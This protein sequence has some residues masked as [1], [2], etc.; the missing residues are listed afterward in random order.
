MTTFNFKK[1]N[2]LLGWTV[3]AIALIVYTMTV[4]PTLSFWDC[5]EYIATAAKLEVGHPPGAPLFQMMGA[6]FAMFATS[7]SQVAFMVNMVSVVSSAFTILFLFWSVTILLKNILSR[8]GEFTNSSAVVVLGSAFVGALAFTFSDSFWFNATEAEVYAMASLFIALLLWL[9]LRWEQDMHTPRGNKWLLIISLIVGLSFGVHFMALLAIPAIGFLYFFKN[10]EKVTVK[11]FIIANV[12]IVAILLFIFKFLLPYTM[13]L[14]GKTEI[15]M[16]NSLGMPFNSGTIFM[17]LLIVAFFYFG[18][19]YTRKKQLPL[20][21]TILLCT[22]F[23]L[24][25]FSTWMMLPIRAN[26]N[27]VINENRPSDAAEVLAYYNREQ[28]GEQQ[29]FYGPMFSDIYAGLDKNNPY[30]DEKPNYQRDYKKGKYVIVN[31]YK[32]AK[33]NTDDNHKGFMPRM[34]STDHA[35]NYMRFTE[36]LDFRLDPNIDYDRELMQYGINPEQMTEDE[37][38]S[39]INQIRGE[40]EKTI[41]QFKTAYANGDI[42]LEGYDQF[43][44]SYGQYLIIEKPSFTQNMKYMFEYQFGYM[45]WRYFMWNFAGRQNDIQGRYDNLDGNWISGIGLIDNTHIGNQDKLSSDQKNNKGRNVYYMIPLLLGFIGLIYHAFKDVKSFYV[46]LVLFLFTGL[47]L[48]IYLNE[49]PFEPRE[50]DYALV[51]SFFVF[52]MWIGFGVYAIYEAIVKYITPKIAG[53]VVIAVTLLGAPVLMASQNWD[54]H[55][56]ADRYTALA[57]AKAYL[58]SCDENAILFTIGDNDTFPLWY[59]QEIEGFRTDVRIVNTSLLMTDWYIDQMKRQAYESAPMPISFEHKQYVQGTRDYMLHI[60]ERDDRWDI[61]TFLQFLGSD[62]PRVKKELNNGHKVNY[63]STNKIRLDV[64]RK[65]VIENKIVAPAQYDS[66]VPY[67]DINIKGDAL[68]KNRMIMLDILANNNWERPIY[69]TGGSFGDDD[70]LWMKDYLQLDGVVYKLVPFRTPIPEDGSPLDMGHIDTEKMY[71]IVMS[72]DW[73]NSESTDIY[74]DPETRKNS[75]TYRTNLARLM[76]RLIEEGKTDKAIKVIDLAME[77]MPVEY[78]GYYTL[79]EPFASG[80]YQTGNKEKAR[81]LLSTIIKKYQED[82]VFFAS[83][84]I[85]DQNSYHYDIMKDIER[86]RSLLLIMKEEGDMEFYNKEKA[87]FNKHNEM[88]K[89]FGRKNEE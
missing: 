72:W 17:A 21:N 8:F 26:A 18:L 43:L 38:Y 82:L 89:R 7:N 74:H 75:I 62:D 45:Y 69:F 76:E 33:Q 11:N 5:G 87:A 54:D 85:S 78:F 27:V 22:L 41:Q 73:G 59:A 48:K 37:Y 79:L 60:P 67:I 42:D 46:L 65:V 16:V 66:I 44:K 28:Y 15:F 50:R 81:A 13:A 71:N 88:F 84:K 58:S 47:A 29:L 30:Q 35:V 57:M 55:D 63:Y 23:I 2:T 14:F 52:S 49:R 19:R 80:Y 64:D 68:Y 4:E 10:Y 53:P 12:V 3:F 20:Y 39:Y 9:G 34:W 86:Y 70:Y 61:K 51:G 77:K 36:P 1:W 83:Q 40:L 56:R 24:I 25:G 32:N 31:N 6:F